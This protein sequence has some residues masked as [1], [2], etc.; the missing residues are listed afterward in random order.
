M[1]PPAITKIAPEY[2]EIL[3]GVDGEKT[4]SQRHRASNSPAC[5]SSNPAG[6]LF[7]EPAG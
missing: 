7:E 2:T 5:C 3:Q 4:H 1:R 6:L